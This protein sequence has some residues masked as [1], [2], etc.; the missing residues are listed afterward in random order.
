MSF[1]IAPVTQDNVIALLTIVFIRTAHTHCEDMRCN[2]DCQGSVE[3]DRW[4][5]LLLG[6]KKLSTE[7]LGGTIDSYSSKVHCNVV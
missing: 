6:D 3:G 7:R 2:C 5:C 1:S 4:E